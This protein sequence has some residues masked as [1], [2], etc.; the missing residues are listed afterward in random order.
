MTRSR[1]VLSS[2][3][4]TAVHALLTALAVLVPA[5][6]PAAAAAFL[7]LFALGVGLFF[8]AY[9]VAVGRSRS[10]LIGVGGLFFLTGGVAPAPVRRALLGA[11]AVQ[12]ANGLG[13]AV[14]R[15]YTSLAFGV[16][17]PVFGL[18]ATGLWAAR[19]GRFDRRGRPLG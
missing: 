9:A 16:L 6:R 12:V 5:W 1:I 17:V 11:L 15:P 18:A 3:I 14:A 2:W 10:D 13:C 8:W 4:A 19:H 7:V